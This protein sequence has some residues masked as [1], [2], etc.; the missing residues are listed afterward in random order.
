ML[1]DDNDRSE[2]RASGVIDAVHALT[3]SYWNAESASAARR[4]ASQ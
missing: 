3:A 4:E 2:A 1:D